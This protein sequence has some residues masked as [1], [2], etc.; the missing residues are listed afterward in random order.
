MTSPVVLALDEVADSLRIDVADVEEL[1]ATGQLQA[2]R[3]VNGGPLVVRAGDL[4]G[5]VDAIAQPAV[6]AVLTR[7]IESFDPWQ[8]ETRWWKSFVAG[9]VW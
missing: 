2:F 7:A 4:P 6:P 9:G 5:L 8:G 3:L 1:V